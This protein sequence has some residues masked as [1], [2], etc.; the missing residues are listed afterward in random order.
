MG[1]DVA[2]SHLVTNHGERKQQYLPQRFAFENLYQQVLIN[3][4]IENKAFNGEQDIIWCR[5]IMDIYMCVCVCI[6]VCV[7]I[8]ICIYIYI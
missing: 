2:L 5:Y 3:I 1:R 4:Y 6:Y 8:Y 7:Y